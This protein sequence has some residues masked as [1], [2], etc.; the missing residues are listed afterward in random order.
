MTDSGRVAIV[1]GAGTNI[2]RT[3]SLTLAAE[4]FDVV[5]AGRRKETLD[6][7]AKLAA[8]L[9]G[10]TL[11]VQTDV[12]D[13]GSIDDL[14]K[15][16]A[17]TFGRLDLLFN[18]AG[19]FGGSAPIEDMSLE[20]WK[21]TIDTNLTGVF[22]CT[23]AAFRMMKNQEPMGG[24]IINNG[25]IS[26]HTPRPDFAGYTASKHGVTGLT[27]QTSFDGRKYNIDC[28]QIDI[29]SASTLERV[30]STGPDGTRM[31]VS[32][33]GDA[34]RYMANLPRG[35]TVLFMTVMP[36]KMPHIGRG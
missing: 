22:L 7:T 24:R 18:N 5:L 3:A 34:I 13:P 25:S 19:Y 36:S 17:E 23:Q 12:T 1:T 6:E 27:K 14:F 31:D 29:G 8:E 2:G 28:G 33:V 11:V 16:T 4:G 26:A 20:Q 15:V 32:H 30:D 9:P 35:L 21:T 10:G